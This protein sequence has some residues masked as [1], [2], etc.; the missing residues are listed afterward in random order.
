M[1]ISLVGQRVSEVLI[2]YALTI[3]FGPNSEFELQIEGDIEFTTADGKTSSASSEDYGSIATDLNALIGGA[4]TSSSAEDGSGLI[5][6]F[7]SGARI[8]VPVDEEYEAWGVVGPGGYRVICMP[9]GEL[10]IW[11]AREAH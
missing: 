8:H 4:V 10:A 6:V 2:G 1:E 5:V 11:S 3:R 7:E 9:G